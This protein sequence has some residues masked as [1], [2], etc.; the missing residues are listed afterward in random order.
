M[1]QYKLSNYYV[2]IAVSYIYNS[3]I[4]QNKLNYNLLN[5]ESLVCSNVWLLRFSLKAICISNCWWKKVASR[6]TISQYE[7]RGNCLFYYKS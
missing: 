4:K 6:F 5:K 2:V 7:V 3:I 1:T